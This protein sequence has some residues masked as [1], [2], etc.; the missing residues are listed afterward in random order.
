M[1]K[2][3][4]VSL[5]D[6]ARRERTAEPPPA[7]AL[8]APPPVPAA[9][10]KAWP[11]N[12]DEID[13]PSEK[14]G[15]AAHSPRSPLPL[16]EGLGVRAGSGE[17]APE[18]DPD[19]PIVI[20]TLRAAVRRGPDLDPLDLELRLVPPDCIEIGHLLFPAAQAY[21][22]RR[23]L[24]VLLPLV[25]FAAPAPAPAPDGVWRAS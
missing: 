1:P 14:P 25:G 4:V 13:L 20:A 11:L 12:E 18:D 17:R 10:D 15:A 3:T 23:L 24:D 5:L 6:V 9:C 21:R 2:K 8:E 7:A 22:L 16:G 19:A